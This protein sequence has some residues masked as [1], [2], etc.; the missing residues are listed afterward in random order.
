VPASE[1]LVFDGRAEGARK[2]LTIR[3]FGLT[4]TISF[5]CFGHKICPTNWRRL[6]KEL[7]I[8]IKTFSQH[9]LI[10]ISHLQPNAVSPLVCHEWQR[11]MIPP[12]EAR[13][14]EAR[15]LLLMER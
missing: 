12:M 6:P 1:A 13:C 15:D 3:V 5:N 7:A 8:C 10:C 2:C 11:L 14:P 4:K 9:F